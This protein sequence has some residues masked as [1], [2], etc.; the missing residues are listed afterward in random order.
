MRFGGFRGRGE[1]W[2]VRSRGVPHV[3]SVPLLAAGER[4]ARISSAP[5]AL[6]L[7]LGDEANGT[8]VAKVC[9]PGL[10]RA[11]GVM[12][13]GVAPNRD[14]SGRAKVWSRPENDV[15]SKSDA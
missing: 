4:N 3:G 9:E 12:C 8:A 2:W 14:V 6:S 5:P 15:P 11:E 13:P 1:G 10:P 7:I